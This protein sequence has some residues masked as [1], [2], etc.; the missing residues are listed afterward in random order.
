MTENQRVTMAILGEKMD[1]MQADVSDI[2]KDTKL[3]TEE[4]IASEV[5]WKA[6]D[7]EHANLRVKSWAGDVGAAMTGG[8]A[9]LIA[10]ASK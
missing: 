10:W 5:L 9:A 3:N 1:N 4:R 2:K 6:H 7:K 8:I